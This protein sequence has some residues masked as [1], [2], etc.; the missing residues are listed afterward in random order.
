MTLGHESSRRIQIALL[1]GALAW[2]IGVAVVIVTR[3][4]IPYMEANELRVPLGGPI[5]LTF[6]ALAFAMCG[7][8][9]LQALTTAL[10][11]MFVILMMFSI[12]GFYLPTVAGAVY[13]SILSFVDPPSR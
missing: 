3:R 7:L 9:V 12:G 1:A 11:V 4:L 2:A 8:R 5:V 6:V 13:A 10:L